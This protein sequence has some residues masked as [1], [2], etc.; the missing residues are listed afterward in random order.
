MIGESHPEGACRPGRRI[1]KAAKEKGPVGGVG[2]MSVPAMPG[3]PEV[4]SF[5][6]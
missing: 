4:V 3:S 1:L 6:C 5:F 2:S